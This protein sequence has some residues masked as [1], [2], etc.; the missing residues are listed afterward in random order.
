MSKAPRQLRI[1]LAISDP[2]SLDYF[3]PHSGVSVAYQGVSDLISKL[4]SGERTW[5]TCYLYGPK[6]SGKTHL[7]RGMLALALAQGVSAE[8]LAL[9]D[10]SSV[11]SLEHQEQQRLVSRFIDLY[12][13]L[14]SRGGLLLILGVWHPAEVENPHLSSRLLAGSVFPLSYPRE[15]ELEPLIFSLMERRNLRISSRSIRY[16]LRRLPRDPLSFDDIF[17]RVDELS[18]QQGKPANFGVVREAAKRT[19]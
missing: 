10:I 12:E 8:N 18:F 19:S 6:G 16:L 11:F 1:P 14:R 5:S 3:I 9:E 2:Y 17:A 13:G 15:D 4:A 7:A